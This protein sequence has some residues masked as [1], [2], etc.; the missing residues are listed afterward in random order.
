MTDKPT[1]WMQAAWASAIDGVAITKNSVDASV[2]TSRDGAIPL[3]VEVPFDTRAKGF[4]LAFMLSPH[5]KVA[6]GAGAFTSEGAARAATDV[7]AVIRTFYGGSDAIERAK[8]DGITPAMVFVLSPPN[9]IDD[10]PD[11]IFGFSFE[12]LPRLIE[13]AASTCL[14][15]P[16]NPEAA[17]LFGALS[18]TVTGFARRVQSPAETD[19]EAG[20][21]H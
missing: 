15:F 7:D 21:V 4:A 18:T 1:G 10:S 5:C 14:A 8:A 12:E 13:V 16:E 17:R 20:T 19:V 11:A 6:L 2:D 3:R 9:E